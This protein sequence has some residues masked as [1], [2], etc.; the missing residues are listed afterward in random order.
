MLYPLVLV[1]H[2]FVCFVLVGVILL[3]A[4]RG[5]GLAEA[6]GGTAQ[7]LFGTRGA[8]Y[9]TRATTACAV[10]FM[11]TSLGLAF[12]SAQRDHSLMADT[13]AATSPAVST[14]TAAPKQPAPAAAESHAHEHAVPP[15]EPAPTAESAPATASPEPSAD[16]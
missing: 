6:F 9:L 10:I 8:V 2:I 4:G 11:L 7:S 5:G 1:I 15:T 14:P 16:E 3:Q 12:L 13:Q